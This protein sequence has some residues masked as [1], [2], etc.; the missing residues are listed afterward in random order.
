MDEQKDDGEENQRAMKRN[1]VQQQEDVS[2]WLI[3]KIK[4]L[5]FIPG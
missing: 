1:V 3:S 4:A 5:Y 2:I